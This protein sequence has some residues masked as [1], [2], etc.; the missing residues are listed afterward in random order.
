MQYYKHSLVMRQLFTAIFALSLLCISSNQAFSQD[1]DGTRLDSIIFTPFNAASYI[2][3]LLMKDDLWRSED[4]SLRYSL[5]RLLDQFHEPFDSTRIKLG[6]VNFDSI[7][8]TMED[9]VTYDSLEVTFLNDSVL[10]LS[11]GI[12]KIEPF[13]TRQRLV[14][15]PV[16]LLVT[17]VTDSLPAIQIPPDI[18]SVQTDTILEISID[19]LLF[20]SLGIPLYKVKDQK[21]LA[22]PFLNEGRRASWLSSDSRYLVVTDTISALIGDPNSPFLFVPSVSLQDSLKNAMTSLLN[23]TYQ[24]DST[25]VLISDINDSKKEFWLSSRERDLQRYWVKNREGDSVTIWLG[26]PEK[27][28][29]SVFLEEDV[30][31]DRM[32]RIF[33]GDIPIISEG[34][35]LELVKVKPLKEIPVYWEYGLSTNFV[36]SQTYLQNWSKGGQSMISSTLDIKALAQYT[37]TKSKT[38]WVNNGRIRY[39]SILT[40]DDGLKTNTD[41]FE[42]NSKFNKEIV[43]KLDFSTSFYTKNQLAKGRNFTEDSSYV[44]SKFLSPSTFTIALGVEYKPFK[45]THL[46]F[47]PISYKNTFVADP[48]NIDVTLH[49]IEAGKRSRQEMGA[50]LLATNK[51]NILD[52]MEVSNTLRLF[53]S[54]FNNP[55]NIDVDWELSL[56]KRIN[57][58]FTIS[59]NLHLIYDNDVLFPELDG[60]GNE[61][62]LPDGTVKKGPKLQLNQYVGLAFAFNF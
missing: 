57:W 19:S 5:E 8:I 31:I 32:E 24:R 7:K 51:L 34:P 1:E 56:K 39:G 6:L 23:Y 52:N 59:G 11:E 58:Y 29:I 35:D 44:I 54:Y 17:P 43:N 62:T 20:D 9:F 22:N 27:H 36:F 28:K 40:K 47:S 55:E 45:D 61:I 48:D 4:H 25:L 53:S 14:E 38:K 50:Q 18:L 26:N 15:R 3:N 10:Y 60:N 21:I 42:I 16:D 2:E 49:G 46:S 37:N 33:L 41:I 13:I 30:N 12:G